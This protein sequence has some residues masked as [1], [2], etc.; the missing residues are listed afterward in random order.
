VTARRVDDRGSVEA[1]IARLVARAWRRWWWIVLGVLA[2]GGAFG[3][4]TYTMAPLYRA[5]TVLVPANPSNSLNGVLNSAL[6]SLGGLASIVGVDLNAGNSSVD[7]V[8][9]VLTSR[10]FIEKFIEDK[11]LLPVLYS[12]IWNENTGTWSEEAEPPTLAQAHRYFTGAVLSVE[13]DRNSQL[14]TLNID[15]TDGAVAAAWANDLVAEV[16]NEMRTRALEHAEKSVAFLERELDRTAFV[17]TKDVI[18]R[19]MENQVNQRMLANVTSEYA[20]RVVDKAMA[21]DPGSPIRPRKLLI[22]AAGIILG[23]TLSLFLVW[24]VPERDR[25]SQAKRLDG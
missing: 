5:S 2:F 20:L 21:P 19:L 13:R 1:D 17:G 6:G 24:F 25:L 23:L 11:G 3:A 22:V 7:E 16:N 12:G 14:T 10:G 4:A 15:W 8:I 18:S 9:A